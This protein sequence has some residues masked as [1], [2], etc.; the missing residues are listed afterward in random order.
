MRGL[1]AVRRA[2]RKRFAAVRVAALPGF[3]R[4]ATS[5]ASVLALP[6]LALAALAVGGPAGAQP[7]GL[8]G[9]LAGWWIAV[10][11]TVTEQPWD[12]Q[13]GQVELLI[14]DDAGRVSDRYMTMASPLIHGGCLAAG[15]CSD[16]PLVATGG[17]TV[18]GEELTF[19]I[20]AQAAEP[21]RG[22]DREDGQLLA[23]ALGGAPAWTVAVDAGGERLTFRAGGR[24]D[25]VFAR[26]A[27]VRLAR[28]RAAFLFLPGDFGDW[29]CLL[30]TAT[31]GEVA[32]ASLP[33]AGHAPPPDF[34]GFLHTSSYAWSALEMQNAPTPDD[35]QVRFRRPADFTVDLRVSEHFADIT[36][37][38]NQS[39]KRA[40][41]AKGVYL[42][43]MA[44]GRPPAE[45]RM[46]AMMDNAGRAVEIGLD[47][48]A[49]RA[50]AT[51]RPFRF[52]REAA[53]A[54]GLVCPVTG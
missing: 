31:A 4:A 26:I 12:G 8:P 1:T 41:F 43:A 42:G 38:R 11:A 40:L 29:P 25:R 5:F 50:Y 34:D 24:A 30:A 17:L 6:A 48:E 52:D 15:L 32:Y 14:V 27:P 16:S 36:R 18:T 22:D 45:A 23:G 46:E 2:D 47:D 49:I 54:A 33:Q 39:E 20:S 13:D 21:V 19:A 9:A 37:P 10:D 53:A 28:L 35:R 3:R 51:F 7:A 44:D